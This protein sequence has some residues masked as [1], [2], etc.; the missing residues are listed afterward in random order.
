M[1]HQPAEVLDIRGRRSPVD[2]TGLFAGRGAEGTEG[3][4]VTDFGCQQDLARFMDKRV[5]E[6]AKRR[7][8]NAP[9]FRRKGGKIIRHPLVALLSHERNES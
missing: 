3:E 7:L 4:G 9:R 1:H 6:S 2:K 8:R 5:G